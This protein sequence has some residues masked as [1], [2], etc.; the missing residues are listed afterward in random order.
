MFNLLLILNNLFVYEFDSIV[1][2]VP[3]IPKEF[4]SELFSINDTIGEITS[5]IGIEKILVNRIKAIAD[6]VLQAIII[7]LTFLDNKYLIICSD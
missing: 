5:I 6:A 4:K 2:E 7:H 1:L 3:I